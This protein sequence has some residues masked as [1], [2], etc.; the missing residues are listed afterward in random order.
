M[1]DL[2]VEIND[3]QSLSPEKAKPGEELR[4][5]EILRVIGPYEGGATHG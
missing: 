1:A 2:F 4:N 5:G 3:Q